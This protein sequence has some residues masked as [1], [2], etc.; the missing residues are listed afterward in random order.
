MGFGEACASLKRH[1]LHGTFKGR[2]SRSEYWYGWL[3]MVII[4]AVI[5]PIYDLVITTGIGPLILSI[6]LILA[7]LAVTLFVE[8]LGL[9]TRRAH[10]AN[11]SGWWVVASVF[12]S[13]IVVPSILYGM[14]QVVF[15]GSQPAAA[16]GAFLL[17]G[18]SSIVSFILWILV[19]LA[20]PDHR[21][22]KY[23]KNVS[24]VEE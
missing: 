6:R 7:I 11:M 23:D 12:L 4:T 10:D 3:T 16:L 5:T 13:M 21:G 22:A 14:Y 15:L 20:K 18:V 17:A 1:L 19:A 9:R 8:E 2:A 24:D